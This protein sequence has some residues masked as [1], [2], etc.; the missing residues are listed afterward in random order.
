MWGR[1]AA[2][3]DDNFFMLGAGSYYG[4]KGGFIYVAV[5][6]KKYVGN[7]NPDNEGLMNFPGG[8]DGSV[9]LTNNGGFSITITS[10]Q[11]AQGQFDQESARLYNGNEQFF[12]GLA[13]MV[14]LPRDVNQK[15]EDDFS[16]YWK[17][18]KVQDNI[19][20]AEPDFSFYK[21]SS[22]NGVPLMSAMRW[23]PED[24]QESNLYNVIKDQVKVNLGAKAIQ[25]VTNGE[26]KHGAF[27]EGSFLSIF[28]FALEVNDDKDH[29]HQG[30]YDVNNQNVDLSYILK[31]RD[32]EFRT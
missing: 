19:Q 8:S 20:F 5:T 24:G 4:W 22:V 13:G 31:D 7:S 28:A 1:N 2:T 10:T 3:N 11:K 15:L 25:W 6:Q 23:T 17:E 18:D 26:K 16:M 29:M 27:G 9:V 14:V 32:T 12:S 21:E 30:I